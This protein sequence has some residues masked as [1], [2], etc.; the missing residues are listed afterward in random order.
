MLLTIRLHYQSM[1]VPAGVAGRYHKVFILYHKRIWR[2]WCSPRLNIWVVWISKKLIDEP[3]VNSEPQCVRSLLD[4][5]VSTLRYSPL[6][7][8]FTAH[9]WPLCCHCL[10]CTGARPVSCNTCLLSWR[11]RAVETGVT[12]MRASAV[13]VIGWLLLCGSYCQLAVRCSLLD[14]PCLPWVVFLCVC[15]CVVLMSFTNVQLTECYGFVR[16]DLGVYGW[17]G[18]F[19]WV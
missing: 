19:R 12:M 2:L 13:Q 7:G 14:W 11:H 6:T 8:C 18:S 17:L 1:P 10:R 16:V 9:L 5:T 15:V 4:A 3:T